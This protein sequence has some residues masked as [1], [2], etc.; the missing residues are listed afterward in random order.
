MPTVI[1][2]KNTL[3]VAKQLVTNLSPYFKT[4]FSARLDD[5]YEDGYVEV[6]ISGNPMFHQD[7]SIEFQ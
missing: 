1:I 7:G 4:K 5:A 3:P 2:N 6:I